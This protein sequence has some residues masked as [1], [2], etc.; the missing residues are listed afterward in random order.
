LPAIIYSA[1]AVLLTWPLTAHLHDAYPSTVLP[2]GGDTNMYVWN[3][4]WLARWLH[5]DLPVSAGQMVFYPHGVDPLSA[6]EGPALFLLGAGLVSLG[7][8]PIAALNLVVLFGLASTALA[9]HWFVRILTRNETVA[10]FAG[11][12]FGFSPFFLI[13]GTQHQHLLLAGVIPLAVLC[14]VRFTR[15][16]SNGRAAILACSFLAAA[17]VSWYYLLGCLL[18]F[19]V[20]CWDSRKVILKNLRTAEMAL[21]MVVLACLLPAWPILA[22]NSHTGLASQDQYTASLGAQPLNMI[23]P[24]PF[25]NI[26]GATTLPIYE[27]F[28]SSYVSGPNYVEASSYLGLPLL[29]LMILALWRT[30]KHIPNRRMWVISLLVFFML[31]LGTY[32]TLGG[33]RFALPY[34]AAIRV[35]PFSFFRSVNRLF[36]FVIMIV[37]VLGSYAVAS[38]AASRRPRR[39]RVFLLVAIF[40][41]LASERIMLPYPMYKKPVP[42]FYNT[43]AKNEGARA[44]ADLPIAPTGFSEYN[45]FQT[46]HAKPIVT[47][48]YFYPAYTKTTFTFILS[49]P[50]LRGSLCPIPA[51]ADKGYYSKERVLSQLLK[52]NIR[53]VVVHNFTLAS[54]P[55]CGHARSFIRSFFDGQ[56]P[57][58]TDGEITV[59]DTWENL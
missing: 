25:T 48:E 11:L 35:F 58:F 16:P 45:F 54:D 22:R 53:Y 26:G 19:A 29:A 56:K 17:L 40:L 7:T 32:L 2:G 28:P 5:G 3:I 39:I 55:Q 30:K 44:V 41:L 43:I 59:Y 33:V 21:Y 47:G 13:R 46:V 57:V 15:D 4:D 27:N 14:I 1:L 12:A 34:A 24:H 37:V 50:L 9:M 18:F 36:V 49:N 6:Y 38:L 23:T 51:G 10:Y 20:A 52:N 31:S 8:G 42:E